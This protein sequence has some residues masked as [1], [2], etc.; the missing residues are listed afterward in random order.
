MVDQGKHSIILHTYMNDSTHYFVCY[1]KKIIIIWP[2]RWLKSLMKWVWSLMK[3]ERK[4][5]SRRC[6]LTSPK[7]NKLFQSII[8]KAGNSKGRGDQWEAHGKICKILVAK[9]VCHFPSF[10]KNHTLF[11]GGMVWGNFF[12]IPCIKPQVD[13]ECSSVRW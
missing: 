6:L 13:W 9:S 3:V 8:K 11:V 4:N 5:L 10:L 1:P 12:L 7:K 2:A